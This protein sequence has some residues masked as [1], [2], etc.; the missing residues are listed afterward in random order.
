MKSPPLTSDPRSLRDRKSPEKHPDKNN[1][2]NPIKKSGEVFHTVRAFQ[3]VPS[4]LSSKMLDGNPSDAASTPNRI[5]DAGFIPVANMCSPQIQNPKTPTAHSAST[6]AR[7][8]HTGRRA[9]VASK[10]VTMPKHGSMA[11]Y[12]S[13]CAKNQNSRCQVTA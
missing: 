13:A 12:T 3:S 5:G 8:L 9:N 1:E 11:T 6:T 2:M 10:C 4:Q 7:S